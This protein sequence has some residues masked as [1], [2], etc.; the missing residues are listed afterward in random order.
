MK[1]KMTLGLLGMI[2]LVAG[3]A[4]GDTIGLY[5]DQFGMNCNIAGS[6]LVN[7]YVVHVTNG[8]TALEFSAP[9]PACW[10]GAT[11]LA[12][13]CQVPPCMGGWSQTGIMIGY[14][15]CRA[16]AILALRIVYTVQE[17]SASCCSYPLLRDPRDIWETPMVVDC[18]FDAHAA[19]GLVST[20]DGNESCPCGYP[21]AAVETTWGCVKALYG[22]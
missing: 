21:V 12:D 15:S 2:C 11:W 8:A 19:T 10:T 22:E 13:Y 20:I 16:G 4:H 6:G 3:L 14:G 9:K 5:A 17:P 1:T 7:V 18:N